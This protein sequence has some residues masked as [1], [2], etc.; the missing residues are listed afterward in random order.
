MKSTISAR[1]E[2]CNHRP[3]GFDYM[4]L[5]LASLVVWTHTTNVVLGSPAVENFWHSPARP[6]L[7]AILGMFFCLSG[8]L[9]AGSLARCRT[10]ISFLGLRVIRLVP[11]LAVDTLVAALIIGP[12]FT[13]LPLGAYFSSETFWSYFLNI[14]GEVHFYLPGVFESH[15]RTEVNAQLWT[16]PYELICYFLLTAAAVVG[17]VRYRHLFLAVTCAL[18]LFY[19]ARIFVL[20]VSPNPMTLDGRSLVM[21]FLLGVT[22]YL[23][24]DKV[25]LAVPYLVISVIAAYV[26]LSLRRYDYIRHLSHRIHNRISWPFDTK[27]I[28]HSDVGRLFLWNISVRISDSA[29][30][31]RTLW[32]KSLD[33][34]VGFLSD[35][36]RHS[37]AV[38]VSG[39]KARPETAPP[40]G[41]FRKEGRGSGSRPPVWALDGPASGR[42]LV[43]P[44]SRAGKR[45]RLQSVRCDRRMISGF[46]FQRPKQTFFRPDPSG[47]LT[48]GEELFCDARAPG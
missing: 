18:I 17:L 40:A 47:S 7:A 36:R 31:V 25:V 38:L 28:D 37:D 19:F 2:A 32:R 39:R 41:G 15:P 27:A 3:S 34:S 45:L 22:T 1:L 12:L 23:Y 20:N 13:V 16:L 43:A 48:A 9:V 29:G 11:A 44:T 33:Q 35:H 14:V 42:T 6:F 5:L 8:F 4:R 21:S 10:M 30:C 26:L 24:R 46:D